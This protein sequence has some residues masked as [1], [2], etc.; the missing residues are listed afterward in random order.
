MEMH[1]H[2]ILLKSKSEIKESSRSIDVPGLLAGSEPESNEINLDQLST[3]DIYKKVTL[4]IK[5]LRSR[6]LC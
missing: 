3:T 6:N 5:Q 1:G 2:E 4:N